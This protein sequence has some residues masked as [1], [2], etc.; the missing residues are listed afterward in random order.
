MVCSSTLSAMAVIHSAKRGKPRRVKA[1]AKDWSRACQIDQ[2]SLASVM[3]RLLCR[4]QLGREPPGRFRPGDA[5][6]NTVRPIRYLCCYT[7]K[8]LLNVIRHVTLPLWHHG[9]QPVDDHPKD[10]LPIMSLVVSTAGITDSMVWVG[11]HEDVFVVRIG[12]EGVRT[13]NVDGVGSDCLVVSAA[14][15]LL[16]DS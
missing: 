7:G 14:G 4:G 2:V 9:K 10:K 15:I 3:M 12:K 16:R 11:D 13:L 8:L 1:H 6:Y 5:T